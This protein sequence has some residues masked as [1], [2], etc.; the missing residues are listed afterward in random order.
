MKYMIE[1]R[2][3][4]EIYEWVWFSKT[5]NTRVYEWG[6]FENLSHTSVPKSIGRGP[7]GFME[8][9]I[10]TTSIYMYY[11]ILI[12]HCRTNSALAQIKEFSTAFN[13]A[14]QTPMNAEV[15]CAMYG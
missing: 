11:Q 5:L 2:F 10:V 13:C 15:K 1:S 12:Y 6:Y 14:A 8:V 7:R 4:T 9:Y 3:S